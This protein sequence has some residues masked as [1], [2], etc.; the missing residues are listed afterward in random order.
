MPRAQA[1]RWRSAFEVNGMVPT[2]EVFVSQR[3]FLEIGAHAQSDQD[4]EV[5]GVLVGKWRLDRSSR[6]PFI[7]VEAILPARHTRHGT[8]F[9]TFTQESLL[10]LHEE[11]ERNHP[12]KVMV[13][14]FHTHPHMG[15]FLSGFDSWLHQNFFPEPWQVALVIEPWTETGGFFIR[16]QDGQLDAH[17]YY[18]F[19]ELVPAGQESVVGWQNLLPA[20]SGERQPVPGG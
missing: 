14:W 9:I 8:G 11:M 20:G 13:G 4:N 12:G 3:A 2:T 6:S 18:G 7:V 15:V 17:R 16:D 5:G 1:Q 19:C 10:A